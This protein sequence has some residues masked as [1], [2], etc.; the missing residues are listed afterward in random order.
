MRCH[1]RAPQ[2]PKERHDDQ[3]LLWFRQ[4]TQHRTRLAV[5]EK[6]RTEIIVGFKKPHCWIA[7]PEPQSIDLVLALHVRHAEFQ[8]CRPPGR[9]RHRRDPGATHLVAVERSPDRQR[10]SLFQ[11]TEQVGELREPCGALRHVA[12][13]GGEPSGDGEGHSSILRRRVWRVHPDDA[14]FGKAVLGGGTFDG[15]RHAAE[16]ISAVQV[17]RAFAVAELLDVVAAK[18]AQHTQHHIRERIN[19]LLNQS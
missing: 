1:R 6:H 18:R 15:L 12:A 11:V 19:A 10:P 3:V 14:D 17:E 2:S 8:Y 7:V 5:L 4:R 16:V 9:K 13:S